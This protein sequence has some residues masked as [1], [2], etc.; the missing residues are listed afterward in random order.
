MCIAPAP[1]PGSRSA[2]FEGSVRPDLPYRVRFNNDAW[3]D[4]PQSKGFWQTLPSGR[5]HLVET[6]E[7]G[8]RHASF[9]F[10]F[11]QYESAGDL[12]LFLNGFY[13]TWQLW[14]ARSAGSWCNC[15]QR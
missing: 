7:D 6:E 9:H 3:L 1:A 8:K 2:V 15:P 10:R 14:P 4:L 12:C 13:N 5:R 11:E